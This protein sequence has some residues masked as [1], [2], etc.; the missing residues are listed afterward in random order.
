MAEDKTIRVLDGSWHMPFTKRKPFQEFHRNHIPTAQFF[1]IDDCCEKSADSPEHML[2]SPAQFADYVG[3]LGINNRTHVIVY[4]NNPTFGLFSA[5]R[6]WWT[7]RVFGHDHVSILEGGLPKWTADDYE[8]TDEV[9][10]VDTEMFVP[11]FKPEMVKSFAEM[12]T[13]L[14]E[15]AFSVVDARPAGRFEGTAPEPRP[16]TI[17]NITIYYTPYQK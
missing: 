11:D 10:H 8:L 17:S 7:F 6:V 13:N 16:G 2:P 14:Q 12:E 3:R 5:Q 9:L 15:G 1:D 4:D